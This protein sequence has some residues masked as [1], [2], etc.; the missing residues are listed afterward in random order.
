MTKGGDLPPFLQR[1]QKHNEAY[2]QG[3]LCR[4]HTLYVCWRCVADRV[5]LCITAVL[6]WELF[7]WYLR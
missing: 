5:L 1:I 3:L 6:I 4:H 7:K 2:N